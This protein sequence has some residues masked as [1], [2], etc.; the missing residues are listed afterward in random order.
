MRTIFVLLLILL[1]SSCNAQFDKN[2]LINDW[3]LYKLETKD[4]SKPFLLKN[5]SEKNYNIII[6]KNDYLLVN[7]QTLFSSFRD[8]RFKTNYNLIQNRLVTSSES[9]LTIEKLGKDSLILSQ[10]IKGFEAK[11]LLR[12]F[13]VRKDIVLQNEIKK[14]LNKDTLIANNILSPTFK[15]PLSTRQ[16]KDLTIT[17]PFS[18]KDRP[19]N[20]KFNG[21]IFI[22]VQTKT[23]TIK[24]I[25]FDNELLDQINKKSKDLIKFNNWDVASLNNF[26]I[27]KIPFAFESYYKL[28]KEIESY[29]EIYSF[30]SIDFNSNNEENISYQQTQ[31]SSSLFNQALLEYQNKNYIK[32]IEL[33]DQAYKYNPKKLDAYYNSAAINFGIGKKEEA[34]KIWEY[35]KNEGQ[36]IAES[37]YNLKCKN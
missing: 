17:K 7:N 1:F 35:L 9:S 12:Y 6:N 15:N 28:S 10:N 3:Y 33:F 21:Y 23:V 24:L 26:K 19:I 13:Y 18:V 27:I 2:N 30:Y 29:G 16:L 25:S 34:C 32:S 14:N 4:G 11:D 20:Y 36:K 5:I 22:N 8:S 31:K 37:E